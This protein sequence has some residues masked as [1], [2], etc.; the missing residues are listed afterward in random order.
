MRAGLR[1]FVRGTRT[2]APTAMLAGALLLALARPSSAADVDLDRLAARARRQAA[3]RLAPIGLGAIRRGQVATGVRILER[4]LAW[5][6]DHAAARTQLGWRRRG[7]D[8]ERDH[9]AEVRAAAAVD[10]DYAEVAASRAA[11]TEADARLV[12]E[13]LRLCGKYADPAAAREVLEPLLALAPRNEAL[14]AALGHTRIGDRWC[15]PELVDVARVMEARA[16]AWR[17]VA[18]ADVPVAEAGHDFAI[19]GAF[20]GRPLVTCDGREVGGSWPVEE[21]RRLAKEFAATHAL[22]RLLLGPGVAQWSPATVYV[23]DGNHYAALLADRIEGAAELREA[24]RHDAWRRDDLLALRTSLDHAADLY[25]HC[26]QFFTLSRLAA[27]LAPD[28]PEGKRRDWTDYAWIKEGFAYFATLELWD[29]ATSHFSSSK[30]SSGK[31]LFGTPRPDPLTRDN[32]LAWVRSEVAAG[33]APPL[34]AVLGSSLNN[35]D[36]FDSLM[37]WTFLRFLALLDHA[38]LPRLPEA[39]RTRNDGAQ[40]DRAEAALAETFGRPYPELERLW[41]AWLLELS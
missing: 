41:R 25:T 38:A 18:A 39:L 16:E 24:L 17:A 32:A 22:T 15:R 23:L 36:R 20:S 21:T 31:I 4:V 34:R 11:V 14:H 7:P 5:D 40:A 35:L 9:E 2:A 30:E 27:P 8:W 29:S 37:G 3:G 13:L 6:P 12:K 19:P 33:A 26:Q 28:D 10:T 1:A